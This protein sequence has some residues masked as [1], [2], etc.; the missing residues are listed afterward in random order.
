MIKIN[1]LPEEL[2]K[3]RQFN[4]Y[5]LMLLGTAVGLFLIVVMLSLFLGIQLKVQARRYHRLDAEWKIMEKEEKEVLG[6]E[7]LKTELDVKK[8]AI[9]N[10]S[11]S[12]LLWSGKLYQLSKNVPAS[13]WLTELNMTSRREKIKVPVRDSGK[14]EE[15]TVTW[16]I[17]NFQTMV[18]KGIVISLT[19]EEMIDSVGNFM[20][21][22]ESDEEFFKDFSDVELIFTQRKNIL[23]REVMAFE[24]ACQFK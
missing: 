3:K 8:E 22:L 20:T 9:E 12:R 6:L 17:K 19:G 23:N 4:N 14:K 7:K 11:Q 2:R 16:V 1:L 18:I 15:V 10:L 5:I 21:K 13:I 24:L